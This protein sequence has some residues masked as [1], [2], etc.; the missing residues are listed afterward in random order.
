MARSDRHNRANGHV[1]PTPAQLQ[2][3]MAGQQAAARRQINITN[4]HVATPQ[5][6]VVSVCAPTGQ[7]V[8]F[9]G[10][11]KLERGALDIM[12]VLVKDSQFDTTSLEAIEAVKPGI[13][14]AAN[15]AALMASAVL[16]VCAGLEQPRQPESP[17]A[18]PPEIEPPATPGLVLPE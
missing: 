2:A 15:L 8:S 6:A 4:E 3:A 9:G 10:F 11:S 17:P 13:W 12:A 18:G 1:G 14:N 7:L 16:E 5:A